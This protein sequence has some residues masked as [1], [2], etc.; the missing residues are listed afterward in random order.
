MRKSYPPS[1]KT[2]LKKMEL[3]YIG[4]IISYKVLRDYILDN[5][6][7]SNDK[8]FLNPKEYLELVKEFKNTYNENIPQ[9][10]AILKV[11]IEES[12]SDIVPVNRIGI[13]QFENLPVDV[14]RINEFDYE[15]DEVFYRCGNCG[16]LINRDGEILNGVERRRAIRYLEDYS[17]PNVKHIWGDCCAHK[18]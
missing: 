11:F 12:K 7:N 3:R 17:K 6:L 1:T 14:I 13:S 9:P 16:N 10:F 4:K 8:I 2:D 18:R 15:L 5:S